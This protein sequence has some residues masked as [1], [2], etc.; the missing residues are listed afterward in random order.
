LIIV[1]L[2]LTTAVADRAAALAQLDGE[3]EQVRAMPGN[4]AYRVYAARDDGTA[5]TVVHEWADEPSFT[6][7]LASGSF[8]RSGAVIRPMMTSA[9]VSRRFRAELWETVA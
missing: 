4:L 2:D 9:P 6:S 7:Y 8:A 3:R 5:I 1:I